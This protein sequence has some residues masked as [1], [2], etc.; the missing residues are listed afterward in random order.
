[1]LK[2]FSAFQNAVSLPWRNGQVGGQMNN[3]LCKLLFKVILKVRKSDI[4]A[5]LDYA[6]MIIESSELNMTFGV[7][8]SDEL[9]ALHQI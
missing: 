7:Y 9:R 5:G 4:M 2:D 8:R 6:G 1:V 3:S